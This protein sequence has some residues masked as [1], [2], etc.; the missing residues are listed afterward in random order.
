MG[1]SASVTYIEEALAS[2]HGREGRTERCCFNTYR[3]DLQAVLAYVGQL[4]QE[5]DAA[6]AEVATLRAAL[7]AVH[8]EYEEAIET[9]AFMQKSFSMAGTLMKGVKPEDV[10]E[11]MLTIH[12]KQSRERVAAALAATGDRSDP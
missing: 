9:V 5:R 11:A 6:R 3:T 8:V 12:V 1:H 7:E 10:T 4:E 2:H